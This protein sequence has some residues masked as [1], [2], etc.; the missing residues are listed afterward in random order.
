ME[1]LAK[2]D[3]VKKQIDSLS[4]EIKDTLTEMAT[5]ESVKSSFGIIDA[6]IKKMKRDFKAEISS[7]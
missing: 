6:K 1:A 7:F 4:K 3:Y 2:I 5:H